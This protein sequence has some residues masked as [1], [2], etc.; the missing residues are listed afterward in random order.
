MI[1]VF[2]IWILNS[3]LFSLISWHLLQAFEWL[4]LIEAVLGD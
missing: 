3:V 4:E 2:N 1:F